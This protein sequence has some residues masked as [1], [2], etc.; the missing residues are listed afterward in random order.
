MDKDEVLERMHQL[1]LLAVIRGPTPNLTVKMVDA[2]VDGG[3]RGIEITFSTPDATS[4]VQRIGEKYGHR[5]LLGMGTLTDPVHAK[6]AADAGA[7]F[8]VSPHTDGELARAMKDTNL[9]TM[10]G[11]LTPSEVMQAVKLGSDLV[12]IFPG[13]LTGPKYLKALHGPYPDLL[14]VPT[15]GVSSDNVA[16]WFAA[17]AFAVG[18]GSTLCPAEWAVDRRFDDIVQRA[19]EFVAAVNRARAITD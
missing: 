18:A 4:V 3:V 15:G 6:Q 19:A 8:L 16:D 11:A 13:S 14:C 2:L 5:I 1:G 10:M 12:K 17:G 9:I 7:T